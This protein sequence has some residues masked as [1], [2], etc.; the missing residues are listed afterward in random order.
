M[1][2]VCPILW[3]HRMLKLSTTPYPI[4]EDFVFVR[5]T[6]I[7]NTTFTLKAKQNIEIRH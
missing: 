1:N 6:V 4:N 2:A 3:I 5:L 7:Y